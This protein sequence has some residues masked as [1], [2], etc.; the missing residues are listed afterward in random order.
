MSRRQFRTI[1]L[2]DPTA[3]PQTGVAD[4]ASAAAKTIARTDDSQQGGRSELVAVQVTGTWGGGTVN[5]QI[6][7]NYGASPEEWTN[8]QHIA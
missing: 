7:L 2:F 6:T 8:A 5:P 3:S 4:S 1:L